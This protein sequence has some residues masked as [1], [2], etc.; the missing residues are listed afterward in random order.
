[1]LLPSLTEGDSGTIPN[2]ISSVHV[3]T[4]WGSCMNVLILEDELS[5]VDYHVNYGYFNL[6]LMIFYLPTTE[7]VL[8]LFS[9]RMKL[10]QSQY[11]QHVIVV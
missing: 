6:R 1:M 3:E 7:T 11:V 9:N 2:G 4:Q 8:F 10:V 5:A